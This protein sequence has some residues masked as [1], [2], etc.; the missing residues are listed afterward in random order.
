MTNATAQAIL[1]RPAA[2]SIRSA[3]MMPYITTLMTAKLKMTAA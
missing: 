3:R 1:D 2:C